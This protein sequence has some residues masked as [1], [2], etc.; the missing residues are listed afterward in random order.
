VSYVS[1][2]TSHLTRNMLASASTMRSITN[3]G[4]FGTA[5]GVTE[6]RTGWPLRGACGERRIDLGVTSDP[7]LSELGGVLAG[8]DVVM[9][10]GRGA[11]I[12]LSEETRT[13]S[14]P[15]WSRRVVPA[16]STTI[17]GPSTR[18][19]NLEFRPSSVTSTL[20]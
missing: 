10:V 16:F 9:V 3:S 2:Y 11:G 17:Y 7:L 5:V 14:S 13:T 6:N 8:D 18:D 12:T 1:A 4:L 19:S 20:T 15:I